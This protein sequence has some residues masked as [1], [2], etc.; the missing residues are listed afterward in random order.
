MILTGLSRYCAPV[1]PTAL[2]SPWLVLDG[3]AH[4]LECLANVSQLGVAGAVEFY[5][6]INVAH[7]RVFGLDPLHVAQ[8][9]AELVVLRTAGLVADDQVHARRDLVFCLRVRR[10]DRLGDG[11]DV[12]LGNVR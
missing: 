8:G 2:F 9:I 5:P 4:V 10:G 6:Q 1:A 3:Y 11:T 12:G 7:E